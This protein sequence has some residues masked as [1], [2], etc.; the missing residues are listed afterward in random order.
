[1]VSQ[2]SSMHCSWS[3]PS[4]HDSGAFLHSRVKVAIARSSGSKQPALHLRDLAIAASDAISAIHTDAVQASGRIDIDVTNPSDEDAA[5]SVCPVGCIIRKGEAF[6]KPIGQR[7][8]DRRHVH[9]N[10]IPQPELPNLRKEPGEKVTLA[11][12]SLAGCFG[13]HMSL[14]DIDER[15]LA[16][17]ELVD[18]DR[19]PID[20]IKHISR[21][22][23]VGLIEGGCANEENVRVLREFREHC[24]TLI[25]VGDCAINGGVPAMRNHYSL[26]ECLEEAY[27][28]DHNLHQPGIPNDPELPLLLDRV[29]PVHELVQ[30]DYFIPGCPPSADTLWSF[31]SALVAGRPP[32]FEYHQ[33]HFD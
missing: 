19:S 3:A 17:A 29:H 8:Y 15:I 23:R 16:L 18:F 13:C 21:P 28:R 33:I 9:R 30:V 4:C 12:C 31:L 20:D 22:C 32:A 5:A 24:E 14:L 25:S 2:A 27:L 10:R 6:T 7:D 1:M 11:T 26:R